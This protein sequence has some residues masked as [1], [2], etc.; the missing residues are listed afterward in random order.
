MILPRRQ[1]RVTLHFRSGLKLPFLCDNFE[2]GS[3]ANALNAITAT[4]LRGWNY[5]RL[6][7]I[8]AITSRRCWL[9]WTWRLRP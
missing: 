5:V 7:D 9:R 8:V 4:N 2:W 1:W 6:D 3:E